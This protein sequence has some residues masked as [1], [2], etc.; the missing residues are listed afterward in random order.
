MQKTSITV[1]CEQVSRELSQTQVENAEEKKTFIHHL[2]IFKYS[3]LIRIQLNEM[4]NYKILF[5]LAAIK[6]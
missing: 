5:L 4:C 1:L 3:Y 2:S 6:S